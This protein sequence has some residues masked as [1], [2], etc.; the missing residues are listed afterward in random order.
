MQDSI[1]NAVVIVVLVLAVAL[2]PILVSSFVFVTASDIHS[3]RLAVTQ[4]FEL[5]TSVIYHPHSDVKRILY[6]FISIIQQP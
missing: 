1:T 6:K 3:R 2:A 4:L 5:G